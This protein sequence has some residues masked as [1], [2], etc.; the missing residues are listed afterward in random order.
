MSYF[1]F[2]KWTMALNLVCSLFVLTLVMSPQL[3]EKY[4]GN[5]SLI[6]E[7]DE[8]VCGESK[9]FNATLWAPMEQVCTR[10]Y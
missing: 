5:G 9:I 2:L 4:I 1:K 6:L 10:G 3:A 7:P 8:F